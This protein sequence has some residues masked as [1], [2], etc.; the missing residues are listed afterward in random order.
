MKTCICTVIKDEHEYLDEWIKYHLELGINHIFIFEDLDSQSHKEITDKYEQ[1]TLQRISSVLTIKQTREAQELKHTKRYNIQHLYYRNILS[2]LSI[3]YAS[4]YDWCFVIDADEFITTED[5]QDLSTMLSL[6]EKYDAVIMKWKCYGA[7]G[8]VEKPDYSQKGVVDTYTQEMKGKVPDNTNSF[9]KTAWNFKKYVPEFFFNQHHPSQICNWVN[10]DYEKTWETTTFHNLFVRH[11][12][13]K[14]W[15]EYAWKYTKRG[16]CWGGNRSF[17]FF[18]TINPDLEYKKE[19]LLQSLQQP[20]A[21]LTQ[22]A[23]GKDNK[24]LV[25]LPYKQSGSQGTELEIALSLWRKYCTFDYHFVVI[26]EYDEALQQ[27]FDWVE[28]IPYQS[29]EKVEGQYNA[30]LDMVNKMSTVSQLYGDKYPGFIWMVD[31]N[32]AI[33]Q[34]ALEDITTIHYHSAIFHGE[35]RKPT[36]FWNHNKWKTRM[37]LDR[38]CLPHYNYTTHYP[39][40]FEF[41]K[42]QEI[43]KKYNMLTESYVLEDIY[44]NYFK[45]DT[46]VLDSSIRLGIWSYDIYKHE[47]ENAIANP[48]IKF[49][50]NSVQGW[51]KEL[52]NDLKKQV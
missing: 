16:F 9:M 32:Y 48:N 28:F 15:Q 47:F 33:K 44:F 25:V 42:L 10:T 43:W 7:S 5:H 50:C 46:P 37:L 13:T 18:F 4:E 27:K 1:V 3:R 35:P 45:H 36:Y 34:F 29:K 14:S 22:Q 31:D 2:Y 19:E 51:S 49:M 12:I 41:D 39:C 26:G 11:Y 40:Y 8:I 24:V 20:K 21:H 17:D 30:H 52:E 23:L 38:E 6:Y